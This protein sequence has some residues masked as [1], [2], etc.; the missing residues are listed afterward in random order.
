M[1]QLR[2]N[3]EVFAKKTYFSSATQYI[4]CARIAIKCILNYNSEI[5]IL[6]YQTGLTDII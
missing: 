3:A 5:L 6:T 2:Q 1:R 4:L